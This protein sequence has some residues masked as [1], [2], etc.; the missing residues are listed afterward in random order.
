[1]N[2]T[3]RFMFIIYAEFTSGIEPLQR[4]R[5]L[6][7]ICNPTNPKSLVDRDFLQSDDRHVPNFHLDWKFDGICNCDYQL[8]RHHPR[9]ITNHF[10]RMN[11]FYLLV[12][13]AGFLISL[14]DSARSCLIFFDGRLQSFSS[15]R[16]S[17]LEIDVSDVSEHKK[18]K[19]GTHLFFSLLH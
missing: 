1:M 2:V 6:N 19:K 13:W 14:W 4:Y 9:M 7:N 5:I 8:Q 3:N 10:L 11:F 15:W 17:V 16:F 18:K 12:D